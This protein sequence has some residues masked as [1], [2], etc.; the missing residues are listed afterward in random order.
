MVLF[1]ASRNNSVQNHGT[2]KNRKTGKYPH[3]HIGI[4]KGFQHVFPKPLCP[5]QRSD[6]HLQLTKTQRISPGIACFKND[7]AAPL[8]RCERGQWKRGYAAGVFHNWSKEA[9]GLG[10]PRSVYWRFS[11]GAGLP[12]KLRLQGVPGGADAPS[13]HAGVFGK[14][15]RVSPGQDEI[16]GSRSGNPVCRRYGSPHAPTSG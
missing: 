13:V 11:P 9:R 14:G 12:N 10:G 2:K 3:P 7:A 1:P 16:R 4:L 15:K 5:D 6:D 8:N